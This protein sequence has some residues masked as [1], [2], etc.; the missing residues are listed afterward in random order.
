MN[1]GGKN[2]CEYTIA[3]NFDKEYF[4]ISMTTYI[5]KSLKSFL[6]PSPPKAC[7][8]PHKLT[9][10]SYAQSTSYAK[11]PDNTSSIDEK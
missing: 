6:H 4:N 7:Y 10:P 1:L 9:F 3:W 11:V 2:Y 5:P 8:A